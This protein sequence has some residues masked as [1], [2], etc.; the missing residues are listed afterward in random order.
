MAQLN[1]V[2]ASK[3]WRITAPLRWPGHQLHLLRAQG[4]K[5]RAISESQKVLRK[6]VQW[7]SE[8]NKLKNIATQAADKLGMDDRLK[9]FL[10]S[11]FVRH[12][13]VSHQSA[14]RQ[15]RSGLQTLTPRALHFYLHLKQTREK[16]QKGDK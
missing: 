9:N 12:Q 1:A 6:V 3:S 11:L 2:Y 7:D 16:S 15:A 8:K 5:Q 10:C 4:F 14:T 13:V